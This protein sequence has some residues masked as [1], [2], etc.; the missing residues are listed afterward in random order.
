MNTLI[1]Y[2]IGLSFI[3]SLSQAF[4]RNDDIKVSVNKI[5][6]YANPTE[7]YRLLMIII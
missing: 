4:M 6:P 7:S 2:L 1:S 5:A 3:I